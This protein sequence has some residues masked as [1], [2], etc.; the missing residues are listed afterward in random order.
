MAL[1]D[2]TMLR[3]IPLF[4][5]FDEEAIQALASRV[6]HRQFLSGQLIFAERDPGSEMFLVQF[7]RVELFLKSPD[8]QPISIGAM[9]PGNFFGELAAIDRQP[10]SAGARAVENTQLIVVS[11][12]DLLALIQSH[13]G[14]A[15]LMMQT[16]S[17][18][19]RNSAAMVQERSIRNVNEEIALETTF[20]DRITDAFVGVFSNMRFITFSVVLCVLWLVVNSGLLPFVHSFDPWPFALL[21]VVLARE[22]LFISLFILIK[23]NRQA[24]NDQVRN[25][26]E[27]DVNVRAE[28]GVRSLAKQVDTLQQLILEHLTTLDTFTKAQQIKGS[29]PEADTVPK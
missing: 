11:R 29:R 5:L 27:Y 12:D 1:Q 4:A 26:I 22:M 17:Q 23:Q 14:V 18:R 25:D 10:R 3:N 8:E 20:G 9:G 15:M 6:H 2:A 21:A 7:G 19:L 13:P 28:E 16:L 24:A